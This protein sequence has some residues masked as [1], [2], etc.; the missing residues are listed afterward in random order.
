MKLLLAAALVALFTAP[1]FAR[2]DE[3]GRMIYIGG[4][5]SDE[6]RTK[7]AKFVIKGTVTS[8][9]FDN[10]RRLVNFEVRTRR[11]GAWRLPV[12]NPESIEAADLAKLPTLVTK[13]ARLRVT[14][15]GCGAS[16]AV[17][18]PDVIE[19]SGR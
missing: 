14:A 13:G 19:A 3:R 4:L 17:V 15:Y 9:E 16:A 10:Q 1:P 8:A 2:Y 6:Q 5:L 18:E 12:V 11:R 7:C